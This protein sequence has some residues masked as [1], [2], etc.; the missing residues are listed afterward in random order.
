MRRSWENTMKKKSFTVISAPVRRWRAEKVHVCIYVCLAG[1]GKF[2]IWFEAAV[3][4]QQYVCSIYALASIRMFCRKTASAQAAG[5]CRI[6]VLVALFRCEIFFFLAIVALSFVFSKNCL[7]MDYLGLK[8]SSR[9]L[10]ANC[11]IN[12]SFYLHLILH[13]YATRFDVTRNLTGS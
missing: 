7:I 3:W 12:Y 10:R 5:T 2:T 1:L 11:A 4:L 8:D 6:R 13:T 9:Q